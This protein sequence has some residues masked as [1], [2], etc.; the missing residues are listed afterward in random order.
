MHF[1]LS[2]LNNPRTYPLNPDPA[3][4]NPKHPSIPRLQER[5]HGRDGGRDGHG[6]AGAPAH[7]H[8]RRRERPPLHHQPRE[9][10][11]GARTGRAAAVSGGGRGRDGAGVGKVWDGKVGIGFEGGIAVRT[12]R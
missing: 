2:P 9:L 1:N 11:V 5:R 3:T 6:R 10:L 12:G 4:L 8:A 7:P